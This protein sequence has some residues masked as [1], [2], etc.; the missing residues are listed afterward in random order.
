MWVKLIG[1]RKQTYGKRSLGGIQ[2]FVCV[3]QK[4]HVGRAERI[5]GGTCSAGG[6]CGKTTGEI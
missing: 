2:R 1:N 5:S 6:Y 3:E 4:R